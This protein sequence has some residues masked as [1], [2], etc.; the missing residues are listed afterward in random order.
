MAHFARLNENNEVIEVIVV[1]NGDLL[2]ENGNESEQKGI[3]F[4]Q[5]L[6]GNNTR[7]IQTS[8]NGNFRKRFAGDG[9]R[10]IPET[11]IFAK[12]QPFA[13]WTYNIGEDIWEPPVSKPPGGQNYD[14]IW[15]EKIRNWQI[16]YFI[17]PT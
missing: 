14:W 17:P 5:K 4:C 9:A 11:D 10:Y 3:E 6:F 2:D 7:W 1:G 8:Y 15:D 12:P 13:S 16:I